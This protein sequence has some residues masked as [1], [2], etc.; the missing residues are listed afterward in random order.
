MLTYPHPAKQYIM[1]TDTSIKATGAALSYTVDKKE[2]VV[3]YY[4]KTFSPPQKIYCVT[5]ETPLA[6][7]IAVTHFLS[8][9][10]GREFRLRTDHTSLLWLHSK[11]TGPYT[12]NEVAKNHT[13]V[14]G[15][16]WHMQPRG[17]EQAKGIYAIRPSS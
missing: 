12:I 4:N 9:L 8:Y 16:T 5:R 7:V 14:N 3:V 17:G 15:A 10:Y 11:Y 6:V 2:R 13:S 1:N